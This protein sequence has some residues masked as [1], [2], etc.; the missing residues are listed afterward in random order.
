M[1]GKWRGLLYVFLAWQFA[2]TTL[3]AFSVPWSWTL[4]Q[5]LFV[6]FI[7]CAAF[8]LGF[9]AFLWQRGGTAAVKERWAL[10][11]Q[12]RDAPL[13]KKAFRWSLVFWIAIAVVL[14]VIFN[15]FQR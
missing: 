7:M 13:N 11:Q 1:Q 10:I 2:K 8:V 12:R 9:W 5:C 15:V 6:F 14:V 4:D 3:A